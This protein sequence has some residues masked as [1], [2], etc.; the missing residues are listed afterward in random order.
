MRAATNGHRSVVEILVNAGAS[1]DIQ[2]KVGTVY[3][4]QNHSLCIC[5]S[6]CICRPNSQIS[7]YLCTCFET[8][9]LAVASSL[10]LMHLKFGQ[11]II[12]YLN[13][14]LLYPML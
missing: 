9:S 5:N 1:L 3:K 14:F 10:Y 12:A 11:T 8:Q 6:L 13:Q 7:I 4:A 2:N